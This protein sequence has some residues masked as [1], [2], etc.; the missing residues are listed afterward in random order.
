MPWV[1]A[2][3]TRDRQLDPRGGK[4]TRDVQKPVRMSETLM[5][6][7]SVPFTLSAGS[8]RS[9]ES[10]PYVMLEGMPEGKGRPAS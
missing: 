1:A 9:N 4:S 5:E 7:R 10:P 8:L 2:R 3:A 6:E